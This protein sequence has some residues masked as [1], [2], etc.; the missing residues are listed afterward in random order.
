MIT[1]ENEI[2]DDVCASVR[3]KHPK[4]NI[5]GEYVK[6]PSSFPHLSIVEL[7]NTIVERTQTSSEYENHVLLMYELNAY[8]NKKNGKKTECKEIIATADERMLAN[9][10]TRTMLQPIPNMD[11]ATIYRM[12]A[13]Y[14]AVVSKDKHIFR[15]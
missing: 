4:A 5:T 14:V 9:G 11:D 12:T 1:V 7:D 6:S 15:R 13:R 10:F 3:A 8:S 2:F